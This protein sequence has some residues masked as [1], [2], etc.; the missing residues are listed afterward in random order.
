M[1]Q[2]T[3]S[4]EL[5]WAAVC[6]YDDVIEHC[7]PAAVQHLQ[8]FMGPLLQ[9]ASSPHALLRQAAVY[10][11]RIVAEKCPQQ[12]SQVMQPALSILLTLVMAAWRSCV[13]VQ[14]VWN[15]ERQRSSLAVGAAHVSARQ[16]AGGQSRAKRPCHSHLISRPVRRHL[17]QLAPRRK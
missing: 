15:I 12:F 5:V 14:A 9:S 17:Q 3:A 16:R 7:G 1:L 6:A 8:T 4:P 10:G 11:V 13:R 2:M